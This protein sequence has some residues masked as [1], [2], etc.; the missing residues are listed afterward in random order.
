MDKIKVRISSIVLKI[1]EYD[2]QTFGFI[3]MDGSPNRNAFLNKLISNLLVVRQIRRE[4]TRRVLSDMGRDNVEEI[5]EAANQII[6]EVY[7]ENADIRKLDSEIWIL[8]TKSYGGAFEEI[9]ESELEITALSMAEYLRGLMNE[10]ALLPLFK[11][12]AFAFGREVELIQIA[13]ED[14]IVLRFEFDGEK[15]KFF[16]RAHMFGFLADQTNYIVGYDIANKKIR[17]FPIRDIFG[18]MA[19]KTRFN[20]SAELLKKLDEYISQNRYGEDV[21]MNL[22]EDFIDQKEPKKISPPHKFGGVGDGR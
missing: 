16:P 8:P 14:G 19:L 21:V 1:I 5:Y 10:Y 4:K 20:P 9:Y 22:G 2:A 3:K 12:E 17:S 11:R 7:F 15:Y 18:I 13:A 6:D